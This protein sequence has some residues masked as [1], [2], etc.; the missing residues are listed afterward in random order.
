MF[1]HK[2]L[3]PYTSKPIGKGSPEHQG[4]IRNLYESAQQE[5][6]VGFAH[7]PRIVYRETLPFNDHTDGKLPSP[8]FQSLWKIFKLI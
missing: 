4:G 7:P 6:D 5:I 8:L 2:L 3:R 1:H